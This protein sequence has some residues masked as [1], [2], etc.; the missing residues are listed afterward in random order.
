MHLLEPPVLIVL[1]FTVA[2]LV[3]A[4]AAAVVTADKLAGAW[5]HSEPTERSS[6]TK[7]G[8]RCLG[9]GRRQKRNRRNCPTIGKRNHW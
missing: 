7:G 5:H 1:V 8:G 4:L 6:K 2:G 9:L 3:A